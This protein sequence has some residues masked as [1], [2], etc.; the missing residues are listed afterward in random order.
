MP[1]WR[2]E[3]TELEERERQLYKGL[4]QPFG[5]IVQSVSSDSEIA[6]MSSYA[7]RSH[8]LQISHPH[9]APT[10][11]IRA[12]PE[13]GT[14]YVATF[15]ADESNLQP[16]S[17]YQLSANER[18]ESYR[19]GQ[20]IYRPLVPGEL[21]MSSL[22]AGQTYYSRRPMVEQR[23]GILLRWANQ[24]KLT[25]GD[26]SPI[27][28]K[29]FFQ[30]QSNE[31]SDELRIGLIS[32]PKV[33]PAGANG[34][35]SW[36]RTYP[37]VR[38]D[39]GAEYYLHMK[40]PQND[41]P[42]NLFSV[43]RGHVLDQNGVQI[44]QAR[45]QIALRAREEYFANDNSSTV[46]EIDEKGNYFISLADAATEGYELN[47]PSGNYRKN[48]QLDSVIQV[49]GNVEENV[50]RSSTY[51]VGE[52]WRLDATKKIVLRSTDGGG[53]MI[54]NADEGAE[55]VL[56]STKSNHMITMDDAPGE[57]KIQIIHGPTG[58]QVSWDKLGSIKIVG[59][60]GENI[61]LDAT[62]KAITMTSKEG[63]FVTVK[64]VVTIGDKSGK[65]V[66]TWDGTDTIQITA[67]AN[68][69]LKAGKVSVQGGS[70]DL[71]DKAA[72]SAVIGEQL[73][74]LFDSHIHAGAMGPTGPPLPPNTAALINAN[75]AT[76]FVHSFVK[77]RG[78]I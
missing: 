65:Q 64:D 13:S 18:N 24:D 15:R 30:N 6:N 52:S 29:Q 16:F 68:V 21:E 7:S 9:V 2:Q 54:F 60:G 34:F 61:F 41:S 59:G 56:I 12:M 75:P 39:Y 36:E 10:S 76:A 63:S 46:K 72:F 20:G 73:A 17:T 35:S 27:H 66:A 77:I 26:R 45:T 31:F 74:L 47:I 4:K 40:N 32:R 19:A 3:Y 69:T 67:L 25:I 49:Q 78:N 58:S 28:V 14:Q 48:V 71:G 1:N 53:S 57:E 33:D 44:F 55:Q 42:T 43:H 22:G 62:E 11:W 51:V 50:T 23:A 8:E 38:G 37:Q 5:L 70:I